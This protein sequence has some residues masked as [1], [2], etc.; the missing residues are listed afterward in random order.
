MA[1]AS[2]KGSS[3][4]SEVEEMFEGLVNGVLFNHVFIAFTILILIAA[5]VMIVVGKKKN[6]KS[7]RNYRLYRYRLMRPILCLLT[8]VHHW[9]W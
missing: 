3:I 1:P 4:S 8:V 9:I 5:C 7:M 2:I 6:W